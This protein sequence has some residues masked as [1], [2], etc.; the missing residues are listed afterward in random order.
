MSFG[1]AG[2]LFGPLRFP[3]LRQPL[4]FWHSAC[5]EEKGVGDGQTK[6]NPNFSSGFFLLWNLHQLAPFLPSAEL[7]KLLSPS[8]ED[9]LGTIF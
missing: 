2:L 9:R 3:S 5:T 8:S 1:F 4:T 7:C 6:V